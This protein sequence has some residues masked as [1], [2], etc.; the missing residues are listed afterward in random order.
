M[1][2]DPERRRSLCAA[3]D[4]DIWG[5][6]KENDSNDDDEDNSGDGDGDIGDGGDENYSDDNLSLIHI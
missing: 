3:G 4:D 6:G 5:D 2:T 1:A